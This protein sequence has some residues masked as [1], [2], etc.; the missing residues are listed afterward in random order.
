MSNLW[1]NIRFGT[2]HFQLGPNT[3]TF[4][5]NPYQVEQKFHNPHWKWLAVYVWLG[6]H[7]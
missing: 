2:Y 6:K 3:L 7:L 1:F 5:Q 4:I